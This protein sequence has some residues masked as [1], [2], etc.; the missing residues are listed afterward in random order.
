LAGEE[1]IK[2]FVLLAVYFDV[3]LDFEI[4]PYFTK[5]IV[6]HATGKELVKF[7][8]VIS[9]MLTAF[10]SNDKSPRYRRNLISDITRLFVDDKHEED[11]WDNANEMKISGLYVD[12]KGGKFVGPDVIDKNTFAYTKAIVSRH[13][14]TLSVIKSIN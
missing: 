13:T 7:I 6:K 14:R 10:R 9:P 3:E 2:G 8:K 5:H 12:L 11:W 4:K 1:C